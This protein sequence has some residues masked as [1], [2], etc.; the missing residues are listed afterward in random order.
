MAKGTDLKDDTY[1]RVA[2]HTLLCHGSFMPS[3]NSRDSRSISSDVKKAGNREHVARTCHRLT[4]YR[5]TNE[6]NILLVRN[7]S[8][9]VIFTR[10]FQPAQLTRISDTNAVDVRTLMFHS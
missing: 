10:S 7:H 1:S 9:K 8:A 3:H 5:E 6:V 4:L 2:I